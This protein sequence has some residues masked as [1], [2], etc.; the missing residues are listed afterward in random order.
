[1]ANRDLEKFIRFPKEANFAKWKARHFIN[2]NTGQE[3]TR[4][5]QQ[6]IAK[7]GIRPEE[8]ARIRKEAKV[9]T[10]GS[11]ALRKHSDFVKTYKQK[12]AK[13]L[14]IKES[15][16]KVRGDSVEAIEFRKNLKKLKAFNANEVKKNIK[17]HMRT[18]E[19]Q[20]TLSRLLKDVNFKAEEDDTPPSESPDEKDT[21]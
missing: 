21:V 2:V 18:P 1:M 3:L 4:R 13:K 8:I 10:K 14:G 20:H 6:T 19:Q 11:A 5:Q 9:S 17:P 7:G 15:A 16:V 12:T